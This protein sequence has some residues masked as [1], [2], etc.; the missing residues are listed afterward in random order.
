M[1]LIFSALAVSLLLLGCVNAPP[2]SSSQQGFLN[3]VV[4]G[5]SYN[6]SSPDFV[7]DLDNSPVNY[8]SPGGAD[9]VVSGFYGFILTNGFTKAIPSARGDLPVFSLVYHSVDQPATTGFTYSSR[10]DDDLEVALNVYDES[11]PYNL[12]AYGL[13]EES[14]FLI[15]L[16]ELEQGGKAKGTFSGTLVDQSTGKLV[17]ISGNFIAPVI[18]GELGATVPA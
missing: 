5:R 16:S 15:T 11:A 14:D 17:T 6:F 13:G 18:V 12:S 10:G 4:D 2:S 9:A 7:L 1:K 3:L 8:G